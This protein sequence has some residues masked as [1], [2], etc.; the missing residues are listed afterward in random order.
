MAYI[1][2]DQIDASTFGLHGKGRRQRMGR[3]ASII[4]HEW[5]K[6]AAE[7]NS[8]S[9]AYSM[10]IQIAK[11]TE[12]EC[13]VQLPGAN[14]S[15]KSAMLARIVEFGLGAHGIG[16]SGRFDTRKALLAA[17]ST[18]SKSTGLPY[19][20]IRF[21]RSIEALNESAS[22]QDVN[23][24]FK[25]AN[26]R[27]E[28]VFSTDISRHKT[29]WG[30]KVPPHLGQKI[31]PHHVATGVAGGSIHVAEKGAS[32][33]AEKTKF[34]IFRTVSMANTNPDAWKTRVRPRK[35]AE[36]VQRAIRDEILKVL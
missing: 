30:A 8:T 34:S 5:K 11:V 6:Q 35:F 32:G 19:R 24:V 13:I 10:S 16:S 28:R 26:A 22:G 23:D 18:L 7:L 21:D 2:I 1:R 3:A 36:K 25:A 15:G 29:A 33:T 12:T 4:V 27:G 9:Q 14:I 17:K 20:V 31:K